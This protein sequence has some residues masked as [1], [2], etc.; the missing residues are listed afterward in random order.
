MLLINLK[1]LRE[2]CGGCP[3]H[4]TGETIDGYS[5]ET[6]FRHGCM[7]IELGGQII[8]SEGGINFSGADGVCNF[9]DFKI[10][11]FRNGI[12]I[13]DSGAEHSSYYDD[14]EEMMERWR[15]K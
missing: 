14:F 3:T 1:S 10:F 13:N 15:N 5:F 9:N 6:H 11:A 7:S 12:I 4:Y 8:A 2:Q